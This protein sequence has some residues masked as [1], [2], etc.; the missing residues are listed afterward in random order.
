MIKVKAFS[1]LEMIITLGISCAL[2]LIGSLELK[3]YQEDL[4]FNNTIKQT[5]LALDQGSRISTL[6]HTEVTVSYLPRSKKIVLLG[7]N[8]TRQFDVDS[9]IQIKNL[10]DFS[11]SKDGII[12]PR[13]IAFVSNRKIK[14]IKIQMAWG[15][16]IYDD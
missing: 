15:R 2:L 9:S 3:N 11:I 5:L 7:K 14:R 6:N 10:D 1:L 8:F 16:I 4:I 13:T 12:S